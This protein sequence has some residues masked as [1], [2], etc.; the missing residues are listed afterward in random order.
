MVKDI[1]QNN[2][3]NGNIWR[4]R[5]STATPITRANL[6]LNTVRAGRKLFDWSLYYIQPAVFV[7]THPWNRF[8][9]TS[10]GKISLRRPCKPFSF[11]AVLCLWFRFLRYTPV[12]RSVY[13][14]YNATEECKRRPDWKP[15]A[16]GAYPYP[17]DCHKPGGTPE[18]ATIPPPLRVEKGRIRTEQGD[19]VIAHYYVITQATLYSNAIVNRPG[20]LLLIS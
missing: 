17:H 16:R 19:D 13:W 3:G 8:L 9:V 2:G 12:S 5:Q 6:T 10:H 20:T 7:S 14:R 11:R 1:S 18:K 4:R 15:V